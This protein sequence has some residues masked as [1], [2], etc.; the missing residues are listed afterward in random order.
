MNH[1]DPRHRSPPRAEPLQP[2]LPGRGTKKQDQRRGAAPAKG[3]QADVPESAE[4]LT[5][6]IAMQARSKND[7]ATVLAAPA[8]MSS[9]ELQAIDPQLKR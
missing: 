4:K 2:D 7:K 5:V 9:T 1:D 3:E 8:A 6:A